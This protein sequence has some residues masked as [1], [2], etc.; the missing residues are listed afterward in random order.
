VRVRLHHLL[1]R[2]Q[3]GGLRFDV[4]K[5]RPR[6]VSLLPSAT[7][8]VCALG[9]RDRL[10]GRSHECD[11]P[12]DVAS[13][14]VCTATRISAAGSSREIDTEVKD[15]VARALSLYEVKES[16]LARLHPD[17]IVTQTQCEV[18]AVGLDDV[19]AATA[20]LTGEDVEIVALEAKSL[21]GVF[22]DIRRVARAL[23]VASQG[24]VLVGGLKSRASTI[25]RR[26]ELVARKPT[27]LCLEWLDPVMAAGNWIPELVSM[28][29]GTSVLGRVGEHAPY[30]AWEDVARADPDVI[31]AMP[32]GYDL[33]RTRAELSAVAE[34]PEWRALRAVRERRVFL[35][36]ANQYFNRP[37]PRL[38]ESLEI[39][40][41]VLQPEAFTFG[42][43]GAG[44][45]PFD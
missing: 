11:Y 14:P 23:Q 2:A 31:V 36:D 3:R 17:V 24:A 45:Q 26:A 15:L 9:L 33:E 40:A 25:A 21:D 27:V 35:S 30:V 7:E 10:V 6:I 22:E 29:G 32:C 13:V 19:T 8:I 44:W 20:K 34:R 4:P 5:R 1:G 12:T 43:E 37:G 41:E 38:V 28:A 16:I 42:H 39:L 18:C